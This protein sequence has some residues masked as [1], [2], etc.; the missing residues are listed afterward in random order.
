M[1]VTRFFQSCLL[2]DDT[3]ARIL[4]D[5]SAQEKERLSNFGKI[6]AVCYT[7]EHGDH[8]DADMAEEFIKAGVPVY[9]NESTAKLLKGKSNVVGD[10]QDFTVGNMNIKV[11]ELPHCP[12]VDGSP[13]PQNVGYLINEKLFHPGDGKELSGLQ[14]ENLALPLTGPDISMRDAFTMASTLGAKTVVPIHYDYLGA[15]PEV[16][17]RMGDK[18]QFKFKI[19]EVGASVDL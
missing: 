13:G 17:S 3:G 5:P 11:I 4:I 7:H 18:F 15:N 16:Y 8:F 9:T 12:M 6:N 19:L 2:I 10:G 1:K 14:V